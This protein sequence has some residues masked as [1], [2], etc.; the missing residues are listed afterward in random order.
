M[1][2]LSDYAELRLLDHICNTAYTAAATLYVA[3]ATADP[4]ETATGVS[5]SEVPNANGYAR[6]AITFAAAATRT[7][8][9][10]GAVTFPQATGAGWGIVTHWAIV[11]STTY[12][13]GNV[14]A[15]GAFTSSFNPVAGNTPTIPSGQIQVSLIRTHYTAGTISAASADNSI[16]DSANNFP[17]YTAGSTLYIS[18]FTGTP[19]NNGTVTVTSSTVSKIIVSGITFV[20]DAAG[21]TV[22]ISLSGGFSDYVVNRW[23]D[24]MFRNQAFTKPATYVGLATQATGWIDDSFVAIG[25]ITECAATN[26]YARVLVNIVGGASPTWKTAVAGNVD[27]VHAITFPTPSGSWGLVTSCF[28]IDSASGAGNILCYDNESIVNQTPV[29][30][31]TVQFAIGALDLF[32]S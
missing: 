16:N 5:M 27:N 25:Q 2:S 14:L 17:L 32:L 30:N 15:S 21:E 11:D 28:L 18:G 29:A 7:I 3:L 8:V 31:D 1:G 19:A 26:N 22:R 20:N 10:T 12:G 4:G 24:L 13:A 23:L 9:Q 6:T